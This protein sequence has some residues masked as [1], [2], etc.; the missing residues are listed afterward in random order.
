MLN[1]RNNPG[2][3]RPYPNAHSSSTN[4]IKINSGLNFFFSL[5]H[6][7]HP[8]CLQGSLLGRGKVLEVLHQLLDILQRHGIVVARTHTTNTAVALET[9]QKALLST[10]NELLL[11]GV[12]AATDTE[13][14]VHPAANALVGN[15][16]VHLG[17]LVQSAVDEVRFLVGDLLLAAD[18]LST[19]CG[20]EVGHDLAGDPEVEDGEGVVERVVL[21]DGGI[22]QHDRAGEATDVQPVQQSSGRGCGLGREKVLA[23]NGDSDT[24]DTNVLLCAAL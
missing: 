17:E 2:H 12:I 3:Y 10:G 1:I 23:N 7:Q 4:Q 13:A 9:L 15:D 21:G 16:P 11:L 20:H 8:P 19:K 18:L 24:G 6:N 5:C 14:N 22:V